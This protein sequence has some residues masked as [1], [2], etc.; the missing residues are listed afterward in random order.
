MAPLAHLPSVGTW[1][2]PLRPERSLP[3]AAG[4]ERRQVFD[5]GFVTAADCHYEGDGLLLPG[6]ASALR[7]AADE[8]SLSTPR[9]QMSTASL[10][11]RAAGAVA[12]VSGAAQQSV[13]VFCGKWQACDDLATQALFKSEAYLAS[14]ADAISQVASE[15][16]EQV[17][18]VVTGRAQRGYSFAVEKTRPVKRAA[19]YAKEKLDDVAEAISDRTAAGFHA[20]GKRVELMSDKV[21]DAM[22]VMA[23][24]AEDLTATMASKAQRGINF[25]ASKTSAVKQSAKVPGWATRVRGGA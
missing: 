25:M 24:K 17:S 12:V 10:Q 16:T 9:S 14:Q 23:G 15:K 6:S 4:A 18:K 11:Q 21:T 13:D 20:S 1:M 19:G 5:L 3:A 22:G 8:R 7:D 2:L